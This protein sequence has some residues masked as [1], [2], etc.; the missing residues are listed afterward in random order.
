[1]DNICVTYGS[2]DVAGTTWTILGYRRYNGIGHIE[3]LLQ[4]ASGC[5]IWMAC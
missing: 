1:M 3:M 5:T 2:I 4:A